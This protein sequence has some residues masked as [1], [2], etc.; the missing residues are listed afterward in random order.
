MDAEK[1]N[2][3]TFRKASELSMAEVDAY[4]AQT[5]KPDAPALQALRDLVAGVET[6]LK[7]AAVKH[8]ASHQSV[9]M[10]RIR[11]QL[12]QAKAAQA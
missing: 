10:H 5:R 2:K 7:R 3:H 12:K 8:G 6:S 11:L 1:R 4:A 9:G